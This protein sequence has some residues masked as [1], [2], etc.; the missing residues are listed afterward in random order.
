[1]KSSLQEIEKMLS[2]LQVPGAVRENFL[3]AAQK[4]RDGQSQMAHFLGKELQQFCIRK[5]KQ[6]SAVKTLQKKAL[7]EAENVEES[8]LLKKVECQM[9]AVNL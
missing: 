5:K 8:Q 2:L 1:M 4:N 3:D 6:L 7:K 9:E